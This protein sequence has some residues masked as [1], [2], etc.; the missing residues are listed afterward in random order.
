[1]TPSVANGVTDVIKEDFKA[2]GTAKD[3]N[4]AGGRIAGGKTGTTENYAE[5]WFVGYTSQLSTSVWIGDPRGGQQHPLT[6]DVRIFG[7]NFTS[8]TGEDIAAPVWRNIM[9]RLHEGLPNVG[10]AAPG[11][12]PVTS[13][14]TTSIPNVQGMEIN[15]AVTLLD[16]AGF[17]PVIDQEADTKDGFPVGIVVTQN[18]AAGEKVDKKSTITL[19]LS[20]GSDTKMTITKRA[21]K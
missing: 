12:S 17:T 3:A 9:D 6:S 11:S 19:K 2:P 15:K 10:F 21:D 5:T 1:V 4:L 20:K 18:P 8:A 13:V 16:D 7:R 14:P